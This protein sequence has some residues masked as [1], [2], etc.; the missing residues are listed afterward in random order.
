[1]IKCNF[2]KPSDFLYKNR[3]LFF[4]KKLF[5]YFWHYDFEIYINK[6]MQE[7]METFVRVLLEAPCCYRF[8]NILWNKPIVNS[9]RWDLL[10]LLKSDTVTINF[11]KDFH[12]LNKVNSSGI[13]GLQLIFI[14]CYSSD[15]YALNEKVLCSLQGRLKGLFIDSFALL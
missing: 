8:Q 4:F 5:R 13:Q 11:R 14:E 10:D 1:M 6:Q 3:F 2:Y 7:M 12:K 9:F 15:S